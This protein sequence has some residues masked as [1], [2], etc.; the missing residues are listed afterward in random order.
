MDTMTLTRL[1]YFVA[2]TESSSFLDASEDLNI[3][4]SALSKNIKLLEE[5]LG[6]ELFDRS[7]R[8]AV[9]TSAGY[10]LRNSAETV[11]EEYNKLLRQA[12]YLSNTV[13]SVVRIGVSPISN[14]YSL[15]LKFQKLKNKHPELTFEYDEN[16]ERN[17]V[18]NI[19]YGQYDM[20]V[21]REEILPPRE[22]RTHL[23][24][25]DNIIA[26]LP[27]NHP[28]AKSNIIDLPTL[29]DEKFIFM[30]KNS[31]PYRI[32][33]DACKAA[34]FDANVIRTA[35]IET[36][37]T[38]V[39]AEE[40]VSLLFERYADTFNFSGTKLI[41][42]KIPVSSKIVLAVPKAKRFSTA[43]RIIANALRSE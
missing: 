25:E 39:A 27:A 37:I 22:F 33:I 20:I 7:K 30:L 31:G 18:D 40:G 15:V 35:R 16:E 29:E 14:Q 38:S 19:R 8:R 34:G 12:K 43:E 1:R 41:P 26:V 6:V 21:L 24:F 2:L 4:Q 32:S 3:S 5:H 42:L 28:L 13:D 17:L 11:L 23:I 36:V 9:L 10:A